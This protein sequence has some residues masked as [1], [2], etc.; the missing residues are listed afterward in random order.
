MDL[1]EILAFLN[2]IDKKKEGDFEKKWHSFENIYLSEEQIN[3][4]IKDP[5]CQRVSKYI[6]ESIEEISENSYEKYIKNN[7]LLR[8]L[9][10]IYIEENSKKMQKSLS[11]EEELELLKQMANGDKQ[12]RAKLI[13]KNLGL[14]KFC[15]NNLAKYYNLSNISLANLYDDLFQE[16]VEA[17]I[18]SLDKFDYTKGYR[19]ATYTIWSIKAAINQYLEKQRFQLKVS[20]NKMVEIKKMHKI[21]GELSLEGYNN[22]SSQTLTEKL[23]VAKEQLA[24]NIQLCQ[25][26]IYLDSFLEETNL[27]EVLKNDG[28]EIE[29]DYEK[30]EFYQTFREIIK[31]CVTNKIIKEQEFLVISLRYGLE[32][33]EPKKYKEIGKIIGKTWQRAQQIHDEGIKKLKKY[34]KIKEFGQ[35]NNLY[36]NRKRK[37]KIIHSIAEL[38]EKYPPVTD[39]Q[40]QEGLSYLTKKQQEVIYNCLKEQQEIKSSSK[41]YQSLINGIRKLEEYIVNKLKITPQLETEIL[42]NLKL[43]TITTWQEELK[44]QQ[45]SLIHRKYQTVYGDIIQSQELENSINQAFENQKL[46]SSF[47]SKK[48]QIE[49]AFFI[50]LIERLKKTTEEFEYKNLL[51]IFLEY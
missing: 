46:E 1:E 12:A 50:I 7:N 10:N 15:I 25:R 30:K 29:K 49:E 9:N 17:L 4:L 51:L 39:E 13:E 37:P 18:K 16:G 2:N 42:G 5:I 11:Q 19:I 6:F 22:F 38:K 33:G 43:L 24:E 45:K 26:T 36:M 21:I 32:D 3:I 34:N 23:E 28:I 41:E 48:L 27:H 8:I 40:I 14:V 20:R 31:N 47:R 35:E 44:E